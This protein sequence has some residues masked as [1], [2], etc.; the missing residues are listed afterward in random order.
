VGRH[1]SLVTPV[2]DADLTAE[3]RLLARAHHDVRI[4]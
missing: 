3:D 4:P 2:R 1:W